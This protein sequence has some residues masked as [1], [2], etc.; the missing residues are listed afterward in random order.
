MPVGTISDYFLADMVVFIT[1]SVANEKADPNVG[2]PADGPVEQPK[3]I[4]Q[5][6]RIHRA[7]YNIVLKNMHSDKHNI[8]LRIF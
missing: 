8:S 4:K 7:Y 5:K 6:K 3:A 2:Q 1:I